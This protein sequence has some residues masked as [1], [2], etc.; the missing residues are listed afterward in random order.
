MAAP[1]P[2]GFEWTRA[3]RAAYTATRAGDQ[4]H[5]RAVGIKPTPGHVVVLAARP[6]RIFPPEFSL[7]VRPGEGVTTQVLTDFELCVRFS[8]GGQTIDRVT[9]F[10]ANGRSEV[11]V[12]PKP[13]DRPTD[14]RSDEATDEASNEPTR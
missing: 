1:L 3:P 7:H 4:V 14:G 6:T 9:V 13:S 2:I 8:A 11:P 10:D 5:V 12:T